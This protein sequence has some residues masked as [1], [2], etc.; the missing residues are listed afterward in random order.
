MNRI[1]MAQRGEEKDSGRIQRSDRVGRQTTVRI[2]SA[3]PSVNFLF[4]FSSKKNKFLSFSPE[5]KLNPRKP[6]AGELKFPANSKKS[7]F[8][9]KNDFLRGIPVGNKPIPDTGREQRDA[10]IAMRSR[11]YSTSKLEILE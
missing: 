7:T 4:D 5:S 9:L 10:S 6:V 2:E 8:F 3:Q 11:N 1:G